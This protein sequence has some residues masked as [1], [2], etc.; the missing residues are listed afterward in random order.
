MKYDSRPPAISRRQMLQRSGLG[1][2]SVAL[3]ALLQEQ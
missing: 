1:F 2:G 3:A